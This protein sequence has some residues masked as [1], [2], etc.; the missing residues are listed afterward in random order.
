VLQILKS[1]QNKKSPGYDNISGKLIKELSPKGIRFLAI[2]INAVFRLCHFPSQWKVAQIILIGKPGKNPDLPTS[3]RPISLLSV[4]SKICEKLLLNK[5]NPIVLSKKLIP[6]HQFGF[7]NHH[8]TIEQVH[9]LTSK[10]KEAFEKKEYCTGA[11]LDVAQ[12]FD[13]V[14]HKGL[15]YKLNRM[16]PNNIYQLLYSYLTNR[17]FQVNINQTVTKLYPIN[18]GIPQGSVLGPTLYLL[19]TADLPTMQEITT[20]TYADDTAVLVSH[21][22]PEVAA[23]VLQKYLDV[24]S[25]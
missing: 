13:K 24:A 20:A 16:F 22:R 10:I 12:T 8:A 9:R 17:S 3:Y 25:A 5:I 1:L 15:L 7:C 11:F 19:Y 14:W 21:P 23:E 4:M 6:N 2:L 18:A